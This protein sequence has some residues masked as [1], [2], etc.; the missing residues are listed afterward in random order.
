MTTDYW[1]ETK[2]MFGK[3]I[4]DPKISDEYLK[5][6]SPSYIFKLI[7]NTMEKTGFPKGLYSKKQEN[8]KYFRKHIEHK[9]KFFEKIIEL[10]EFIKDKE[11]D[12]ELIIDI[13][14]ILKG[15]KPEITNQFLQNFYNFATSGKD[16]SNIIKEYIIKRNKEKYLYKNLEIPKGE[17]I[18]DKQ[19]ILWID[20]N[21]KNEESQNFLKKLEE[22]LQYTQ[23][24][25]FNKICLNN[26]DKAFSILRTIKFKIIY[27]IISG[28]LYPEYYH[29]MKRYKNFIKCIPICVICTTDEL[30][31]VYLKRIRHYLL[32]QEIYESI[33]NSYYNYGGITS[34]FYSSLDFISNFYF[35]IKQKFYPKKK[36]DITYEGNIFF[37]KINSELQLIVPFLYN[38]LMSEE[39]KTSDN[40]LQYFKYILINRHGNDKVINLIN[41]LLFTK[42]MPKELLIKFFIRAYT[43]KSSFFIA[44]N[45]A[46]NKNERMEYLTFV[47]LLFEG[48]Y[49]KYLPT[50]EE[51][52]LYRTSK[53]NKNLIE[54]I[55]KQ[56]SKEKQN[57]DKF[58]PTFLIYSKNILSF[59]KDKDLIMI[60]NDNDDENYNVFFKLKNNNEIINK[61]TSNVDIEDISI[62]SQEQEVLFF[63]FTTFILSN[64]YKG[65][66]KEEECIV[67]ELEYLGS[68]EVLLNKYK[69]EEKEKDNIK[70]FF[71]ECF[72]KQYYIK[73]LLE[74]NL[75]GN[76]N[77][78]EK[79]KDKIFSKIKE[80]LKHK[81]AIN[82]EEKK[83]EENNELK[84]DK[85]K[86]IVEDSKSIFDDVTNIKEKIKIKYRENESKDSE[87][88]E[89]QLNLK[90]IEDNN[91]NKFSFFFIPY[92]QK[93]NIEHLW[94]GKYNRFNGKEGKG[95]ELDLKDNLIFDGE[96]EDSKKIKGIEYYIKIKGLKKFEGTYNNDKRWNGFLY[97]I[98]SNNKYQ[99]K[100]GNGFIKEF[101][102]N[103]CLCYE[104]KIENGIKNGESKIF[105]ETGHLIY[106]GNFLNGLRNGNGKEYNNSGDLI[107]EDEF[108]NGIRGN[109]NIYIYNNQ[110]ELISEKKFKDGVYLTNNKKSIKDY[111]F[112]LMINNELCLMEDAN[113]DIGMEHDREGNYKFEGE[114]KNGKKWSGKFKK[115]YRNNKLFIEGEYKNGKKYF[116][117][118]DEF[119]DL[120][121]EG[122]YE[123]EY[124]FKGKQYKKG[125]LIFEGIYRNRK[126]FKGIE[127]NQQ[128]QFIFD[129]IYQN[130]IRWNG[131]LKLY[132][133]DFKL[134]Y[135]GEIRKG[136]KWNGISGKTDK[137]LG[138]EGI[139]KNGKKWNGNG[140]ETIRNGNKLFEWEI[141]E[142]EKYKKIFDRL[143]GSKENKIIGRFNNGIGNNIKQFNSNHDLLSESEYYNGIRVNS[144]EYNKFGEIIFE[145]EYK[146]GK[147]YNGIY[148]TKYDNNIYSY[149][150]SNGKVINKYIELDKEIIYEGEYKNNLKQGKGKEYNKQGKILFIGEFMNGNRYK[151]K[152]F[153]ENGKLIFNGQYK[154]GIPYNGIKREFIG[155]LLIFDG[156]IKNGLKLKGKEYDQ[157]MKLI[158]E[159]EYKNGQKFK[160]KEKYTSNFIFE[161]EY[162]DGT[163]YKGKEF[164]LQ[165]RLALIIFKL[166]KN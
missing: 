137:G 68:Y 43:E 120:I 39:N 144:K 117:K 159:G 60:T 34:D 74:N 6:P 148:V 61:Y 79:L 106:E 140:I 115:F 130:G 119:G 164:D 66:F 28:E 138:F 69:N 63:P 131:K 22:N 55:I 161:G 35:S 77:K 93:E 101:H 21:A 2:S 50:S 121:L 16:Y 56:F 160:G 103:G 163:I 84:L 30:K 143:Y 125:N 127:Y 10:I 72:Q 65:N 36:K 12:F 58:L 5:R 46:L 25:N 113:I 142:D 47:S 51:D 27:I 166:M 70:K 97:D 83:P 102:E 82:F 112:G 15:K 1:S 129:G 157:N 40:E 104:G 14:D 153:N 45:S 162:K 85:D 107:F 118:Y 109:G 105:D 156:E 108:I 96:Y 98:N 71:N 149:Y 62:F 11:G 8:F 20:K 59:T 75:L 132:T 7:M 13:Q 99:I 146:N 155:N 31:N 145:G 54:K 110:C 41:P 73:E 95:I 165:N 17:S 4:D 87:I 42:E 53:M 24:K 136:K 49:N 135:D 114:F 91:S 52:Y 32:T 57:R 134:I 126:K 116:K 151:G 37:E 100:S 23:I 154:K 9:K 33:N 133:K 80:K 141:L 123:N 67:I 3:L 29:K 86:I 88:N 122:K 147:R 78:D 139:I 152:E 26:I 44:I 18:N 19:Y 89:N 128:N 76:Y 90:N 64:I 94:T 48:L 124:D 38:E 150:F 81:F 111:K 158:F 92:F